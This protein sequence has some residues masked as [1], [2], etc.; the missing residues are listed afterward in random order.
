MS[1]LREHAAESKLA[2]LDKLLKLKKI[3][4]TF[5]SL[6][7]IAE[8]TSLRCKVRALG[9]IREFVSDTQARNDLI[10]ATHSPSTFRLKRKRGTYCLSDSHRQQ[11]ETQKRKKFDN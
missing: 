6:K 2:F 5:E 10:A 9:L 11:P 8:K 3:E 7:A 4:Q 1:K